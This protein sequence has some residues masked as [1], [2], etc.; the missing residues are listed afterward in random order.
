MNSTEY[1]DRIRQAQNFLSEARELATTDRAADSTNQVAWFVKLAAEYS[2]SE[3]Y[4][5]IP[6]AY[7]QAQ[8]AGHAG[9]TKNLEAAIRVTVCTHLAQIHEVLISAKQ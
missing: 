5:A 9:V 4:A 6:D 1:F 2:Q 3:L 7:Q 8:T